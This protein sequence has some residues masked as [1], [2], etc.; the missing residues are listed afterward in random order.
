MCSSDLHLFR[1][2]DYDTLND[3]APISLLTRGPM[4]LLSSS[5]LAV[6]NLNDLVQMARAKPGALNFAVVGPGSPAR[7]LMEAL[8]LAAGIDVTMISYKSAGL[9]MGEL[10]SG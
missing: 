8:K 4:M 6:S 1:K 3:L 5:S 9:A 7:L 2:L 10:A